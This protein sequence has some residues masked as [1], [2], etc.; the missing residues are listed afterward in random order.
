MCHC[1]FV[2]VYMASVVTSDDCK[3]INGEV[4]MQVEKAIDDWVES[5]VI[6]HSDTKYVHCHRLSAAHCQQQPDPPG[7]LCCGTLY[8]NVHL[9]AWDYIGYIQSLLCTRGPACVSHA[10][11]YQQHRSLLVSDQGSS[12]AL[13]PRLLQHKL[14]DLYSSKILR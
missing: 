4:W 6:R 3:C 8:G 5:K 1:I 12:T 13:D 11:S 9:I 7:L 2:T 14:I 10:Q